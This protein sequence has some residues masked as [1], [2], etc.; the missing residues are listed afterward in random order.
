MRSRAESLGNVMFENSLSCIILLDGDMRVKEMNP[1]A[2]KAFMVNAESIKNKPISVIID[3]ED[4]KYVRETKNNINSK[5]VFYHK[6]NLNFLETVV[7]LSEQDLVMVA[8]V[9]ITEV[10]QNK[11][12]LLELKENTINAAQQVIEKQMRV[13]Q[14]IASL[15]GETT[16][17]TKMTLTKLKKIVEGENESIL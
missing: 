12:R 1:A 6:Y 5:K 14:E 3:N 8:L 17:E 16:A 9:D 2:E 13:A 4:F 15:L 7:Y 11:K 10:E